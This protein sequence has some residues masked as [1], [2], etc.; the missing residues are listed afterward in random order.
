MCSYTLQND[1][2]KHPLPL[3]MHRFS[4]FV[5]FRAFS[6]IDAVK[7]H[8]TFLPH[9]VQQHSLFSLDIT[10]AICLCFNRL[11]RGGLF[12]VDLY[13]CATRVSKATLHYVSV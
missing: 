3:F 6:Y 9:F 7:A 10:S 4:F 1:H 5:L 8:L 11:N 13:L 2:T 12:P